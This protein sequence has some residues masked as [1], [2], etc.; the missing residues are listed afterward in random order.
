MSETENRP[1]RGYPVLAWLVILGVVGFILYRNA[2]KSPLGGVAAEVVMMQAQA[3]MLVAMHDANFPGASGSALYRQT[4]EA[5]EREPVDASTYSKG[6][7][8]AVLAGELVSHREALDELASLEE[9]RHSQD[10]D[11]APRS[12]ATADL[13]RRLYLGYEAGWAEPGLPAEQQAELRAALR[14]FGDLALAPTGGDPEA[15]ATVLAPAYRA[16]YAFFILLLGGIVCLFTGI[17]LLIVVAYLAAQGRLRGMGDSG[18]GGIYAETFAAYMLLYV[19]IGFSIRYLPEGWSGLW[20]NGLAMLLSLAALAW[21]VARGVPWRLVR[22]DLG[23][24]LGRQPLLE[25]LYGVGTYVCAVPVLAVAVLLIAGL[26]RLRP[27]GPAPTH[28]II[29]VALEKGW[30]IWVQV[31]FVACVLAPL[32]EEIMF[33]GALYRHVREASGGWGT[34]LSVVISALATG[35]VFAVIHP[36]GWLA[37]PALGGLAVVFALAREWRQTLVPAMVAHGINNGVS[38]LMLLM[39]A[40]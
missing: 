26:S 9:E 36:Q 5:L 32:V 22:A 12:I 14:W 17:L 24:G 18:R 37:V 3:R 28:P 35:F 13:L 29:G 8:L 4:K 16:L 11:A 40:S 7:R 27:A 34:G 20:V 39:V 6:L 15:R 21:P 30:W 19:A 25:T 38:T 1:R 31:F 2:T 33:R 10:L 23:L